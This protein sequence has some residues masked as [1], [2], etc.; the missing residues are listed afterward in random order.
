MHF[1]NFAT[2]DKFSQIP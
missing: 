1:M 2:F